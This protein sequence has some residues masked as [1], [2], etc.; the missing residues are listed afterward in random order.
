MVQNNLMYLYKNTLAGGVDLLKSVG[1]Q[2]EDG[3]YLTLKTYDKDTMSEVTSLVEKEIESL[4]GNKGRLLCVDY[5][6]FF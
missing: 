4:K 1:F 3:E 2:E 6:N 5:C